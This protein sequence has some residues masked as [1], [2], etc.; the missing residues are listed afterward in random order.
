MII[1]WKTHKAALTG[2]STTFIRGVLSVVH[3]VA[4][5][6]IIS[7]PNCFVPFQGR[8]TDG[9]GF[10]GLIND[11]NV[12]FVGLIDD[13]AIGFQGLIFDN[14]GFNG[15]IGGDSLGFQGAVTDKIGF[16]GRLCDC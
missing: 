16:E 11:S 5:S 3:S 14:S 10:Q 9:N 2:A 6:V 4:S 15:I 13:S 12:I 8:I 7:S 1:N